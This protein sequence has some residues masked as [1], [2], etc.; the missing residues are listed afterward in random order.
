M[1]AAVG[2]QC[3]VSAAPS[4]SLPALAP[5]GVL[6]TRCRP[7][8]ADPVR[9]SHGLQ[10]SQHRRTRSGCIHCCTAGPSV[11]SRG[12]L[13]GEVPAASGDGL[14]LRWP[15]LGCT[16]LLERLL[17]SSCPELGALRAAVLS[18]LP[19]LSQLCSGCSLAAARPCLADM[20]HCGALL[21]GRPA[22][23]AYQH[24]AA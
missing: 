6:P 24:L 3:F 1:E 8:R 12:D 10:V 14:L 5:R 4:S 16:L 17:P 22:A 7:S 9:A 18:F 19:L 23:P 15:V 13:L 2:P 21:T 11:A 20:W